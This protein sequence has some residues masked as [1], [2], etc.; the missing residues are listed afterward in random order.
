[1]WFKRRRE[2]EKKIVKIVANMSWD[3]MLDDPMKHLLEEVK[4]IWCGT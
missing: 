3:M 4:Y 2:E 1:M